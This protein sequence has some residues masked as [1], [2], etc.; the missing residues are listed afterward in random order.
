M[1]AHF[2]YAVSAIHILSRNTGKEPVLNHPVGGRDYQ[3]GCMV[4]GTTQS[5]QYGRLKCSLKSLSRHIKFS[6]AS[7]KIGNDDILLEAR[8]VFN[9][10]ST[11]TSKSFNR[12]LYTIPVAAKLRTLRT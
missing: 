7:L 1:S 11:I 12:V 2:M 4:I 6:G 3:P 9:F 8:I 5:F 10:S